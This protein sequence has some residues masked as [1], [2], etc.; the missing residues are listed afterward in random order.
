MD[1]PGVAKG[2]LALPDL[3][4]VS[5]RAGAAETLAR[6]VEP[7]RPAAGSGLETIN[8]KQLTKINK[9]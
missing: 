8:K 9:T 6:R 4:G 3:P 5:W 2:K 1:A 7:R